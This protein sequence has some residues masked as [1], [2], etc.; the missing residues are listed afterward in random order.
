MPAESGLKPFDNDGNERVMSVTLP[1]HSP[2]QIG[3]PAPSRIAPTIICFRSGRLSLLCPYCPILS[4]PV[5]SYGAFRHSFPYDCRFHPLWPV[6]RLKVGFRGLHVRF[7]YGSLPSTLRASTQP[8]PVL[9]CPIV[10]RPNDELAGL[11]W[12]LTS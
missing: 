11:G 4:T 2:Q 8:S 6:L 9:R 1:G 10:F 3:R 7:R 12:A 5:V